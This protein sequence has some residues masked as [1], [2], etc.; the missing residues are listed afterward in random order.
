MLMITAYPNPNVHDSTLQDCLMPFT[1]AERVNH[2][3][4]AFCG[5]K[6]KVNKRISVAIEPVMLCIYLNRIRVERTPNGVRAHK[7]E[8]PIKFES[9]FY[10]TSL[11]RADRYSEEQEAED[12][13]KSFTPSPSTDSLSQI[14]TPTTNND[15]T[16]SPYRSGTATPSDAGS[17][18]ST[19]QFVAADYPHNTPPPSP[20]DHYVLVAV[21][22]H[23]GDARGGHYICYRA[24]ETPETDDTSKCR[25][26]LL[27]DSDVREVSFA[28][29]QRQKAYMLFYRTKE[30]PSEFI[31]KLDEFIMAHRGEGFSGTAPSSPV[32]FGSTLDSPTRKEEDILQSYAQKP[33]TVSSAPVMPLNQTL[34]FPPTERKL[35][36]HNPS[37]P[38]RNPASKHS[39]YASR[40]PSHSATDPNDLFAGGSSLAEPT[41]TSSSSAPVPTHTAAPALSSSPSSS[42]WNEKSIGESYAA[43]NLELLEPEQEPTPSSADPL[44]SARPSSFNPLTQAMRS[45]MPKPPSAEIPA[46]KG[47][48]SQA[49]PPTD[50]PNGS[51]HAPPASS[52]NSSRPLSFDEGFER[53][54]ADVAPGFASGERSNGSNAKEPHN[55]IPN[56]HDPE[57]SHSSNGA[58]SHSSDSHG[59]AGEQ[60]EEKDA[61]AKNIY[62]PLLSLPNGE[63]P[64]FSDLNNPKDIDLATV[65]G[66]EESDLDGLE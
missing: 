53:L 54:L 36:A 32:H 28:D 37:T 8:V 27:S 20:N 47:Q 34:S 50:S 49:T 52:P 35:P 60:A 7:I 13:F 55:G 22:V 63:V 65:A 62:E 17:V 40:L 3:A 58:S 59:P 1:H 61:R 43:N 14:S 46:E 56:G 57:S 26:I 16:S 29:V 41:S 6:R 42:I 38:N 5:K 4:C 31:A 45:R 2:V 10:L 15:T 66:K 64:H 30:E 19:K 12:R 51:A 18:A 48:H 21:V 33:P 11:R 24:L 23:L 25:W 44:R 39:P 9:T